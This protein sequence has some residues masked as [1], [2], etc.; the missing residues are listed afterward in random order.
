MLLV[1]RD[2][3]GRDEDLEQR[4]HVRA[5]EVAA[6]SAAVG[7]R[8]HA[9]HVHRRLAVELRDVPDQRDDLD[10]G[11]DGDETVHLPVRVVEAKTHVVKGADGSEVRALDVVLARR[12]A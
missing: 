12:T 9:V 1:E 7:H 8:D 2:W 11:V 5:E 10:L 6:E 4:L 3:I